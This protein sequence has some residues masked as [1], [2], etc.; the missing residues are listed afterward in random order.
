MR[1]LIAL[2]ATLSLLACNR[3]EAAPAAA[4]PAVTVR[5]NG[6]DV[7]TINDAGKSIDIAA[8]SQKLRGESRDS[9]KRKYTVDGG[10]VSYE[11]KPNEEGGFKL[12]TAG[13]KL[14]WKVKVAA[15]KIKISNNEEN[16]NPFELKLRD[17]NRVKVVGPGDKEL[18]NVR[19]DGAKIE[20]ENAA[21]QTQFTVASTNPSGAYGVL[22]LDTIPQ[23]ER[24]IL[25]AEILA[26]GR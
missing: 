10:A 24:A 9:G 15:D 6:A 1:T 3:E 11:I 4:R 22:L 21:G 16:Q 8:G 12:R 25:V 7:L 20:V 14:L 23:Q 13:G 17:G 2:L 26:R 19:F 5:A 18:G